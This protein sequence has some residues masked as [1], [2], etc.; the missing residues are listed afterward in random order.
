V[1]HPGE[2]G[3]AV[4][5]ASQRQLH[6]PRFFAG[7]G[8]STGYSNVR[9]GGNSAYDYG[10]GY[11]D[12][13][14]TMIALASRRPFRLS[15]ISAGRGWDVRMLERLVEDR[16]PHAAATM[17]AKLLGAPGEPIGRDVHRFAGG[18]HYYNSFYGN[19][20]YYDCSYLYGSLGFARGFSAG[21]SISFFRA[22]QLQQAGFAVAFLGYDACGQP[23]FNV[24]PRGIVGTPGGRPPAAGEFPARRLP[25]S[26]PRNP[27]KDDGGRDLTSA[28]PTPGRNADQDAAFTPPVNRIPDAGSVSARPHPRSEGATVSE[29][30]RPPAA[31][32]APE[33]AAPRQSPPPPERVSAPRHVPERTATP[34]YSPP[35]VR[36]SPP[37]PPPPPRAEPRVER[38]R[39]TPARE[40]KSDGT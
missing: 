16:D 25:S 33:R 35:P 4:K 29:R 22:A 3:I 31:S 20:A 1:L 15:N 6:L 11:S 27:L 40:R 38:E 2:T 21:T 36:S 39:P 34:A 7:Y 24:F 28:R 26:A 23:M 5:M 10:S 30:P 13:R 17:L 8:G 18:Q 14:G 12:T 19:S 37:P 9:G 32:P